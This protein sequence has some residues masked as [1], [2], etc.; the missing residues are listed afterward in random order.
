MFKSIQLSGVAHSVRSNALQ[1]TPNLKREKEYK[2]ED[3]ERERQKENERNRKTE[4]DG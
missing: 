2:K 3:S 4:I 1:I